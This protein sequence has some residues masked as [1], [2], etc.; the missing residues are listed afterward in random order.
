MRRRQL[1]GIALGFPLLVTNVLS[2]AGPKVDVVKTP[3][4][5]C[6]SKWVDHL[7]ANGFT[8]TVRDVPS[9][10]EYRRLNG[11]PDSLGSC[12]TATVSGYVI[13]GHVP[14]ADIHRLLKEKPKATGLAVPGMPM[15]SPGMEGPRKDAYS[16]L[17]F[18]SNGRTSVF[19]RHPGD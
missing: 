11:V 3:T 4:C 13:E 15:G 6:C 5:G 10:A 9:T 2:G 8:V 16:T 7:K 19:Q 1:V 12:H 18:H 14:A 17:L